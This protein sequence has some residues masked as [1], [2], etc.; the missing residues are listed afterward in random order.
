MANVVR[1]LLVSN[2]YKHLLYSL[3]ISIVFTFL[4]TEGLNI[5]MEFKDKQY[6]NKFDWLDVLAGT[7]GGIIGQ[8]IQILIIL[9]MYI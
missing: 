8:S 6:G 3:L 5:G 1:W 2:R 7:I 9:W 4:F